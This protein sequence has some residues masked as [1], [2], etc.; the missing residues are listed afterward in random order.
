MSLLEASFCA[1]FFSWGIVLGL[2]LFGWACGRLAGP[3]SLL[4]FGAVMT[5]L[6]VSLILYG[7]A[8]YLVFSLGMFFFGIANGSYALTFV[9]VGSSVP[10]QYTGAAFGFA[11]MAILAVGG[12]LFQ[13]LI[14]ILA[15]M[16][17][18]VV[19]DA[20]AL[21]VLIWAQAIGLLLLLPLGWR[22]R[23]EPPASDLKAV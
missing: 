13:P 21:S 20:N 12:L 5:G 14:G 11:N 18:L 4:A 8:S 23:E 16:R 6:S 7:P 1:S 2:P 10:R 19:P 9:V 15:R 17:G 22:S 3:L